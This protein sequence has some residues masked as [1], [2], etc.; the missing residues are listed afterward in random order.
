MASRRRNTTC[1]ASAP[2]AAAK[3][4]QPPLVLRLI[5][6]NNGHRDFVYAS[7]SKA[8]KLRYICRLFAKELVF[9]NF[10]G[11]RLGWSEYQC[12]IIQQCG[13]IP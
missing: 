6:I 11:L 2:D 9:K 12:D 8:L 1:C 5:V 10:P 3:K 13:E 4:K 7:K